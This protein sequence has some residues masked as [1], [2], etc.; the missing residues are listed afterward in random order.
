MIQAKKIIVVIMYFTAQF[1]QKHGV[2][3]IF[4]GLLKI[5]KKSESTK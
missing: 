2:L 1:M 5:K 3:S 4:S